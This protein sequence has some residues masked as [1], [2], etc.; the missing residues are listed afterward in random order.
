[1][2]R[3][4]VASSLKLSNRS[5]AIA[6]SPLRNEQP[7]I[8]RQIS[9]PPHELTKTVHLSLSLQGNSTSLKSGKHCSL[10]N[11]ILQ[12]R[13]S[14]SKIGGVVVPGFETGKGA[15]GS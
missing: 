13:Q 3:L 4:S 14:G 9:D 2:P 6:V 5:I 7:P 15:R 11:P 1:M 12:G 8:L 10:T